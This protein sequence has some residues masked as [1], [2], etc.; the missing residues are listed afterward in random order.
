MLRTTSTPHNGFTLV[1]L[2]VVIAV[3]GILA[4]LL[5]P[6]M[7][8]ARSHARRTVCS[9]NLKQI[10]LALHQYAGDNGDKLPMA[11]GV[12]FGGIE[13]NHFAFFYK[14]LVK[15]Y[16]G[17][18]G[19]SSSQDLV[20]ACPADM[21]YYDYPSHIFH[22]ESLRDQAGSDYS[23][24]GFNGGNVD[25]EPPPE[26]LNEKVWRGL[27]GQRM[28]SVKTPDTTVLA[29][30][31]SA[32]FPFSW[33]QP[34][35]LPDDDWGVNDAKNIASFVDGHIAYLKV[36]WNTNFNVCTCN[37]DPPSGYDYRWGSD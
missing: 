18:K 11:D 37:Y 13:T 24:Y 20:F 14:R 31:I 17:L 4:A 6:A 8:T 21:F 33:H 29:A 36:F 34:L 9:N 25:P 26:F 35:R 2:L 22:S 12:T 7:S 23:S 3:I 16:V 1:E 30:E 19:A 10:N 27:F 32:F 15:R 28:S 5:L